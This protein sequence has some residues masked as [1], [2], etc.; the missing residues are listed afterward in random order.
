MVSA[1][2]PFD[3]PK[4][5][6]TF[7]TLRKPWWF[8]RFATNGAGSSPAGKPAIAA[9]FAG[10]LRRI[11]VTVLVVVERDLGA[12]I[13]S[14]SAGFIGRIIRQILV[15]AIGKSERALRALRRES[16][17]ERGFRPPFAESGHVEDHADGRKGYCAGQAGCVGRQC[18]ADQGGGERRGFGGGYRSARIVAVA[19][20]AAARRWPTARKPENFR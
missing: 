4:V 5:A 1:S 15:G 2:W 12:A 16:G 19:E 9:A 13:G 7:S 11:V 8:I 14:L 18:S 10:D 6:A 20:R 17:R 3:M